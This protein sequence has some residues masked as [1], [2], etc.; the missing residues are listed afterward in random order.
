MEEQLNIR[1]VTSHKDLGAAEPYEGIQ[2]DQWTPY[3]EKTSVWYASEKTQNLQSLQNIIAEIQPD[4]I[5]LNSMFSKIFTIYPLL[6]LWQKKIS[7]KIILSPRGMLKDSALNFKP[8]KKKIFL[9]LMKSTGLPQQLRFH[10]TDPEEREAIQQKF[11]ENTSVFLAPNFP[12]KVDG[13]AEKKTGE[14]FEFCFVGRIHP[15]KGLDTVLK[16]LKGVRESLVFNIIGSLEDKT[17]WDHCQS[18]IQTL[19]KNIKVHYQGEME[20]QQLKAFLST[21]HF[22]VLPTH[23]E[24]FGHA[25]FEA[26]S[27][28]LPVIISDQTPWKELSTQQTGWDLKLSEIETWTTTISKAAQME[29]QEYKKWSRSAWAF[30]RDFADDSQLTKKYLQIFS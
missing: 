6:L 18:M 16:A 30:A 7:A 24:N 22:F 21:Q 1:V 14:P 17:Y 9:Q 28:G 5:Y 15:I 11:G 25:I 4:F 23:G 12:Q 29:G 8:L 10:A 27:A 20:H 26:F 2:P 19:P 13:Y 3:S